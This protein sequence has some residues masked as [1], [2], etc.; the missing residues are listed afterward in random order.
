MIVLKSMD[1]TGIEG[2]GW[3]GMWG[4]GIYVRWDL[5]WVDVFI[6]VLII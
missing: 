1:L 4:V 5:K 2:G 6:I 3:D